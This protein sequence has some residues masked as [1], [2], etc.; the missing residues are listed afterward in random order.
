VANCTCTIE[1]HSVPLAPLKE[2]AKCVSSD[3]RVLKLGK[4]FGFPNKKVNKLWRQFHRL[5][6]SGEGKISLETFSKYFNRGE[7][8]NLLQ[9]RL[10]E[11]CDCDLDAENE[12]KDQIN[13]ADF[14]SVVATFCMMNEEN[15]YVSFNA[16]M[17]CR[18]NR[19]I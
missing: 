14:F 7:K 10:F 18:P 15:I 19:I 5:D 1:L 12:E 2:M 4:E 16:S 13:F 8:L 11:L 3:P 9:T 17:R 6:T